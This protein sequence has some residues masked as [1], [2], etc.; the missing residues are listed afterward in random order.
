MIAI[1]DSCARQRHLKRDI[2]LLDILLLLLLRSLI[3]SLI[4]LHIGLLLLLL[5]T[6][7]LLLLLNTL[8]LLLLSSA[9][10]RSLHRVS[11]MDTTCCPNILLVTSIHNM[12][13]LLLSRI[14]SLLLNSLAL[15]NIWRNSWLGNARL[16]LLLIANSLN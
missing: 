10:A 2:L 13:L 8:L 7:L 11:G 5:N 9:P 15:L 6:L 14:L 1:G 16:L 12:V 4:L 3:N